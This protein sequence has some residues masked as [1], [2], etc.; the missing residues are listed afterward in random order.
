[1]ADDVNQ[2]MRELQ[3]E[4]ERRAEAAFKQS[5]Q[6]CGEIAG[7]IC[8]VGF[9]NNKRGKNGKS[10]GDLQQSLVAE[11][12]GRQGD[13]LKARFGSPLAYARVQHDEAFCHPGV[14][15]GRQGDRY[16]A[17]YFTRTIAMIFGEGRD[18]LG[19]YTGQLPAGF[20]ELLDG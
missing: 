11:Y 6:H 12:L 20:Q 8:P 10:G 5:V 13:A 4:G 7:Q 16:A 2:A 14:Y 9:Y 15:T 17:K 18:P 3:A 19:R 1:M